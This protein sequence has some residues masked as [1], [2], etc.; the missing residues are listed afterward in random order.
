MNWYE[1]VDPIGIAT[2]ALAVVT[3]FLAIAVF[4][5][6]RENRRTRVEDRDHD[7]KRR[8]LD[9]ILIW[10]QDA[11][12]SLSVSRLDEHTVVEANMKANLKYIAARGSTAIADAGHFDIDLQE[13]VKMAV[14]TLDQFIVALEHAEKIADFATPWENLKKY[15]LTVILSASELRL[16]LRL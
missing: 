2:L 12:R 1:S 14:T 8:A 7:S 10:A 6:I 3:A 5:F 9:E 4:W 11:S 15:F 16:K 13:K